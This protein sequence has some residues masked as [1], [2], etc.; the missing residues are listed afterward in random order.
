MISGEI[1]EKITALIDTGAVFTIQET[2]GLKRLQFKVGLLEFDVE[3]NIRWCSWFPEDQHNFHVFQV[4]GVRM[5]DACNFELLT[6][7]G[8]VYLNQFEPYED[9]YKL[10]WHEWVKVRDNYRDDMKRMYD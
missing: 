4:H 5:L 8:M 6:N 1:K 9:E 3:D 2:G 7:V 10:Y